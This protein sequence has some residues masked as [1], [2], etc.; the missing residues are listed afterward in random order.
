MS[1]LF[2]P[3]L[4]ALTVTPI[5]PAYD[6]E[7]L[8]G[9]FPTGFTPEFAPGFGVELPDSGVE[10]G[11]GAPDTTGVPATQDGVVGQDRT[12][13]QGGD[14]ET[15]G[16][17]ATLAAAGDPLAAAGAADIF[18][19]LPVPAGMDVSLAPLGILALGDRVPLGREALDTEATAA[20]LGSMASSQVT[21][22]ATWLHG[23]GLLGPRL[24]TLEGPTTTLGFDGLAATLA[25]PPQTDRPACRPSRS[26]DVGRRGFVVAV[27][28]GDLAA[29][30][31][32]GRPA[33]ADSETPIRGGESLPGSGTTGARPAD[34]APHA[35]GPVRG[36]AA[37][38]IATLAEAL[39]SEVRATN[40]LLTVFGVSSEIMVAV[41]RNPKPGQILT[42]TL[43]QIPP[44]HHAPLAGVI[45]G[46]MV[47]APFSA[48][49]G[50]G[51][52]RAARSQW[53]E[54]QLG[55]DRVWT[56]GG[57]RASLAGL[58]EISHPTTHPTIARILES[59]IA[60]GY[61]AHGP[62]PRRRIGEIVALSEVS[63]DFV[64]GSRTERGLIRASFAPHARMTAAGL[65]QAL[66]RLPDLAQRLRE[67][68][69]D[70]EPRV[71]GVGRSHND[72][73]RDGGDGEAQDERQ[74]GGAE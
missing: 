46:L 16:E 37:T 68:T 58:R 48:G 49:E 45:G 51:R 65:I 27:G 35:S 39:Q 69:S 5:T 18:V 32:S 28:S 53:L 59:E 6:T 36:P 9:T 38:A 1:S 60:R 20:W 41:P 44:T 74:G 63:R 10:G 72:A 12:V 2:V 56:V 40:Q 55:R 8:P 29:G 7:G 50:G 3:P 11:Q 19:L 31:Q 47:L 15:G 57:V 67:I 73:R 64:Q 71:A 17:A 34:A 21:A 43:T 22:C 33:S 70:G 25:E 66:G 42:A 62:S 14:A 26:G 52:I 24:D 23:L 61:A 4:S 30:N 13:G 54:E